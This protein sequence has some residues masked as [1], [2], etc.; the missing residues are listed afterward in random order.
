MPITAKDSQSCE[1]SS[2]C[3]TTSRSQKPL[4]CEGILNR[5]FAGQRIGVRGTSS[6]SSARSGCGVAQRYLQSESLVD[7][8]DQGVAVLDDDLEATH[9]RVLAP[10]PTPPRPVGLTATRLW[11]SQST[12]PDRSRAALAGTQ[13]RRMSS[14]GRPCPHTLPIRRRSPRVCMPPT[15]VSPRPDWRSW[16]SCTRHRPRSVSA[17]A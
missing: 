4:T 5:S 9:G 8:G 13:S 16:L 6:R 2:R 10:L 12:M 3:T 11:C 1:G 17:E 14:P 15:W 7:L